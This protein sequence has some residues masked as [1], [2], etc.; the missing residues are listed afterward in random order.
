ML[1]RIRE[2][3]Y[4]LGIDSLWIYILIGL[5][6]LLFVVKCK[7]PWAPKWKSITTKDKDGNIVTKYYRLDDKI[8]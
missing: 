2:F 4:W 6:L 5:T 1:E 7:Y 8:L 3:S